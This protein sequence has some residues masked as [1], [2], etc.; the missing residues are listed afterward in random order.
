LARSQELG[1]LFIRGI[2]GKIQTEH[3]LLEVSPAFYVMVH[4]H[5]VPQYCTHCT[6]TI[7]HGPGVGH[8]EER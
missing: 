3:T 6:Q 8:P 2:N 1:Q 4:V 7:K 5:F